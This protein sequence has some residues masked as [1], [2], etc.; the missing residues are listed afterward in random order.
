[1]AQY[2]SFDLG[3]ERYAIDVAGVEVVLDSAP[4]TWVPN[5]PKVVRG[6]I[7]HRGSV[8]PA[9]D[10]NLA[11]DLSESFSRSDCPIIVTDI[12]L[13]GDALVVGILADEVHEVIDLAADDIEAPPA[14]GAGKLGQ[15]LS[16]IGKAQN[17]FILL[18]DLEETLKLALEDESVLVS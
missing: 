1:M 7:N 4:I 14:S 16:G 15:V 9:I 17:R 8:I 18:L 13:D 2:L 10:L 12:N 11:L 5:S 6:V 3:K